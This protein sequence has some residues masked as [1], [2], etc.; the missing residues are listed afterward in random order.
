MRLGRKN[1][2]HASYWAIDYFTQ[3]SY[4]HFPLVVGTSFT[5]SRYVADPYQEEAPFRS[6]I[7]EEGFMS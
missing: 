4:H 1:L 2:H 6:C 3:I 7:S 5:D